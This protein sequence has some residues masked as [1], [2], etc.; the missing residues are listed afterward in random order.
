MCFLGYRAKGAGS[1]IVARWRRAQ[2]EGHEAD[3][4]PFVLA[5]LPDDLEVA[6]A[7]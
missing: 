1:F 4:D 6:V 5:G 3:V 7:F 2:T